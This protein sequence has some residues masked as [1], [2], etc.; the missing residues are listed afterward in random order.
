MDLFDGVETVLEEGKRAA[1]W[2]G[3][4]ISLYS[5]GRTALL[6]LLHQLDNVPALIVPAGLL[7]AY[8]VVRLYDENV[9]RSEVD[10]RRIR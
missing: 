9:V 5:A 10:M 4:H 2:R 1:T 6:S 7:A 3:V 8:N